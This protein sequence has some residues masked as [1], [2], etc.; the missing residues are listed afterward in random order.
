MLF[1]S[2]THDCDIRLDSIRMAA[3]LVSSL[4]LR[5]DQQLQLFCNHT[6]TSVQALTLETLVGFKSMKSLSTKL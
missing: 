4:H 1:L 3:V 5:T 6:H 2:C